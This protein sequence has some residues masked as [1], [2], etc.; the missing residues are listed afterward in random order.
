MENDLKETIEENVAYH[1]NYAFVKTPKSFG[2]VRLFQIGDMVCKRTHEIKE[3][4]QFCFELTCVLD[5]ELIV[6]SNNVPFVLQK[7][8]IFL[9]LPNE[10]HRIKINN[11]QGARFMFLGFDVL[12]N[13]P[14]YDELEDLIKEGKQIKHILNRTHIIFETMTK[15]L[16]E[17]SSINVYSNIL[18]EGYLNEI[19]VL[20]LKEIN[21]HIVKNY[22]IKD[23]ELLF[24]NII[25]YIEN[26]ILDI[27]GVTD[28]C[29]RFAFSE[30]YL[31]HFFSKK[32]GISLYQY[33]SNV[34]FQKAMS[35]LKEG[36]SVTSVAEQLNYTSIYIFSRAFKNKFGISPTQ[37]ISSSQSNKKTQ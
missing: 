8:M 27:S 31:S 2:K 30:S 32:L 26:N 22:C 5:G 34:K 9:S 36:N 16:Q 4:N 23:K 24:S 29:K 1:F 19:I 15:C 3:H 7:N 6:Y 18:I 10:T 13:H 37:Y 17:I 20:T 25:F 35:L 14:L 33:F 21:N 28:I 12:T 11:P